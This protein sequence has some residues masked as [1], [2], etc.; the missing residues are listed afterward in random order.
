MLIE[1][2]NLTHL[3]AKRLTVILGVSLAFALMGLFAADKSNG[4]TPLT[5]RSMENVVGG[6][7]DVQC[8]GCGDC[9]DVDEKYFE[10]YHTDDEE[11]DCLEDVKRCIMN[12]MKSATCKP[13]LGENAD[14]CDVQNAFPQDAEVYQYEYL[15]SGD[16]VCYTM[17]SHQMTIWRWTYYGCETSSPYECQ[18]YPHR[19]ACGTI[20]CNVGWEYPPVFR[21]QKKQCGCD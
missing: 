9:T 17:G 18:G 21:S 4:M 7:L 3:R 13:N 8:E 12:V 1:R 6:E 10:C 5:Q 19:V 2:K 20:G 14:G 11:P 15:L 16:A